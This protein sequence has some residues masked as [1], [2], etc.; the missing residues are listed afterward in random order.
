MS[1]LK[2]SVLVSPC[3]MQHAVCQLCVTQGGN[4]E[5]KKNYQSKFKYQNFFF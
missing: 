4:F 2:S 1:D 5:A 3:R